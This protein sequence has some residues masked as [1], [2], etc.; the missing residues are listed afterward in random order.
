MIIFLIFTV[1]IFAVKI[2]ATSKYTSAELEGYHKLCERVTGPYCAHCEH[3][4]VEE[5]CPNQCR[6]CAIQKGPPSVDGKS[7]ERLRRQ[8]PQLT[9]Q[10]CVACVNPDVAE[11]CLGECGICGSGGRIPT[12]AVPGAIGYGGGYGGAGYGTGYGAA[13]EY[14]A[15]TGYGAAGGTSFG[16]N[17]VVVGGETAA[18]PS[19][20]YA[21]SQYYQPTRGGIKH[22][23]DLL[24]LIP[25]ELKPAV[26]NT[27]RP[28]NNGNQAVYLTPDATGG[29]QAGVSSVA[30]VQLPNGQFVQ[31]P[32]PS[33]TVVVLGVDQNSQSNNN[34]AGNAQ[35]IAVPPTTPF[36]GPTPTGQFPVGQD[37]FQ[38]LQQTDAGAVDVDTQNIARGEVVDQVVQQSPS[39]DPIAFFGIVRDF[40]GIESNANP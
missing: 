19:N 25:K 36:Q 27:Q 20:I 2:N 17:S 28:N 40:Y 13:T 10:F 38:N 1:I 31:G 6:E 34:A 7:L 22:G 35:F 14:G 12:D 37:Y 24:D 39:N 11:I 16:G 29:P 21:F 18:N 26:E 32:S 3:S 30:G 8:C 23:Q 5:L 4:S 9:G 33:G 15:A